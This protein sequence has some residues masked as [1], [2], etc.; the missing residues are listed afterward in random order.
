[1]NNKVIQSASAEVLQQ[2]IAV[3]QQTERIQYTQSLEILSKN[4]VGKHTRH[5]IEY[6]EC[7]CNSLQTGIVNYDSRERKIH[8]ETNI[9][10][11]IHTI[12]GLSEVI[13]GMNCNQPVSLHLSV[14][15]E[16]NPVQLPSSL[17]RELIYSIEHA[18]HH[19]AILRIAIQHEGWPMALPEN[20][21]V[22]YATIQHR[23][24]FC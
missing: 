11:A 13:T 9:D 5:I 16:E 10:S 4:T 23:T 2:L 14:S 8:L 17:Y 3:L 6:F 15:R 7:V 1:M 12:Q 20:F 24:S 21:G 22:A 18:I 19:M